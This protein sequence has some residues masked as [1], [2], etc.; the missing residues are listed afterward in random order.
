MVLIAWNLPIPGR[1]FLRKHRLYLDQVPKIQDTDK[2]GYPE[3]LE[4]RITDLQ[5]RSTI[6]SLHKRHQP[7]HN[8]G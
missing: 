1:F 6:K 4:Y 8:N 3:K 2:T 5:S 7:K